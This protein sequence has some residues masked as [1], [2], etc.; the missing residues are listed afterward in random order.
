MPTPSIIELWRIVFEL[1]RLESF[2][3]EQNANCRTW[4]RCG[5]Q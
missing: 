5:K 1:A 2:N 3:G 4:K